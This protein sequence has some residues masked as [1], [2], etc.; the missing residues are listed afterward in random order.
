MTALSPEVCQKQCNKIHY[1]EFTRKVLGKG[2]LIREEIKFFKGRMFE[3][4][5]LDNLTVSYS[6]LSPQRSPQDVYQSFDTLSAILIKLNN[7][8]DLLFCWV[9]CSLTF[10]TR[11]QMKIMFTDSDWRDELR[12]I[13][14]QTHRLNLGEWAFFFLEKTE[15]PYS[16]T[17]AQKI[18]QILPMS[19][20]H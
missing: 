20:Q 5:V 10:H 14:T 6:W 3:V 4:N 7:A 15:T 18:R 11:K 19:Q 13:I 8:N 1:P 2:T 9:I 16:P 17:T 12:Q